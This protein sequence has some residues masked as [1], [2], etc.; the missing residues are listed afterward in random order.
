MSDIIKQLRDIRKKERCSQE[1]LALA[2]GVKSQTWVSNLERDGRS[3]TLDT[4]TRWA[5]A[6]GYR[7]VLER[8]G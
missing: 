5:D 3:P 7:L 6:L 8:K 4:L 1:A 2:M